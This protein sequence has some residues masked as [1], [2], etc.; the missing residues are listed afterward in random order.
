MFIT[1]PL[2]H[3]VYLA[4]NSDGQTQDL[5]HNYKKECEVCHSYWLSVQ[6]II[7]SIPSQV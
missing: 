3:M 1:Y 7:F 4:Y 6:E 2:Y 5:A